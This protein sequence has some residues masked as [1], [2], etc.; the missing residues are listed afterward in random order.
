[1]HFEASMGACGAIGDNQAQKLDTKRS[2]THVYITFNGI[3]IG[4]PNVL[5]MLLIANHQ[6]GIELCRNTPKMSNHVSFESLY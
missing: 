2:C 6:H 3:L 5:P 1:M 4:T